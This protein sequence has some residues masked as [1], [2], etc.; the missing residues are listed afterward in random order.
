MDSFEKVEKFN[1]TFGHAVRSTYGTDNADFKMRKGLVAEEALETQ[2][3]FKYNNR[4]E[5]ADGLA[6]T[7]F[8]ILG[9]AQSIGITNKD[10]Q[11]Y[12]SSLKDIVKSSLDKVRRMDD[13]NEKMN[14]YIL[15]ITDVI[16][17]TEKLDKSVEFSD[18]MVYVLSSIGCVE[19][20]AKSFLN[21]SVHDLLDIVYRSNMSKLGEDGLPIL[22][23]DGKVLKGKDYWAPT[24]ELRKVIEENEN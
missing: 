16:E 7:L 8:T 9:F 18:A 1:T 13:D 6:D 15:A 4:V 19:I 20:L 3:S 10:I 24:E 2:E 5:V 11:Y 17:E 12:E 22:R 21:V 14:F 23:E